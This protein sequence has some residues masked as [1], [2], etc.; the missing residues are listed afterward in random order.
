LCTP[1]EIYEPTSFQEA[2]DL[3]NGKEWTD[4]MRDEMDSMVR[5]QVWE[6]DL[7]PSVNILET[8]GF[9]R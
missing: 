7:P 3:P 4:A 2:I 8:S 9:S 1:L 6:L 5:N